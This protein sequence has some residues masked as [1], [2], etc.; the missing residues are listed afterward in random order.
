M[1]DEGVPNVGGPRGWLLCKD[2]SCVRWSSSVRL[3]YAVV[4][5]IG[6][7]SPAMLIKFGIPRP[8][9][10]SQSLL[11][12]NGLFPSLPVEP[13]QVKASQTL[14]AESFTIHYDAKPRR[15]P[16]S[17]KRQ[18]RKEGKNLICRSAQSRLPCPCH[19]H[20]PARRG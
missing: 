11:E 3:C 6:T 10:S 2:E 9:L 12:V 15:V 19:E 20:Q 5:R 14:D 17:L 13:F 16:I 7:L 1:R 8:S 4:R 18:G